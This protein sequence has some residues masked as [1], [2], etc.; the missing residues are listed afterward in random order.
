[1]H[2]SASS[3]SD[4]LSM[5]LHGVRLIVVDNRVLHTWSLSALQ[6]NLEQLVSIFVQA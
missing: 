3:Y 2:Q 1:M 5:K 4:H 6:T